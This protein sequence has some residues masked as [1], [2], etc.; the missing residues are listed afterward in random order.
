MEGDEGDGKGRDGRR[1]CEICLQDGS[2]RQGGIPW[3]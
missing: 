2:D 1:C 3:R